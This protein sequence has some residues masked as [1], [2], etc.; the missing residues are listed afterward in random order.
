[1]ASQKNVCIGGVQ[2]DRQTEGYKTEE[3]SPL[4]TAENC[5]VNNKGE[6]F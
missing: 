1:M 6:A 4:K 3:I 2:K 5:N